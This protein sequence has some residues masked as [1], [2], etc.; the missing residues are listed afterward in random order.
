MFDMWDLKHYISPINASQW[1]RNLSKALLDILSREQNR[2]T[3]NKVRQATISIQPTPSGSTVVLLKIAS[4][5]DREF[6]SLYKRSWTH[7]GSRN[8]PK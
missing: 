8:S 6:L 2:Q 3:T 5:K 7:R 4:S 1:W